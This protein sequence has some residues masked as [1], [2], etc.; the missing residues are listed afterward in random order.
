[1]ELTQKEIKWVKNMVA[2]EEAMEL[3]VI[4]NDK[5]EKAREKVAKKHEKKLAR[6]AE[7]GKIEERK[8]L[9]EQM[10]QE[11]D[12]AEIEARK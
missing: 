8:A 4:K 10:T 9:I 11:A 3:A 7:E 12:E 1:M 5:I 2:Q 6:L